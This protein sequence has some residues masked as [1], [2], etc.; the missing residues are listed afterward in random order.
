MVLQFL[1]ILNRPCYFNKY[2]TVATLIS[3]QY[4]TDTTDFLTNNFYYTRYG[5]LTQRLKLELKPLLRSYA[6]RLVQSHHQ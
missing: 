2:L 5:F 4:V 6:F 3:V 1:N